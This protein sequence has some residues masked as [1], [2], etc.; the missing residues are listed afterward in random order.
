MPPES[1]GFAS[2]SQKQPTLK[3]DARQ[4]T[5][6]I[7]RWDLVFSSKNT[8]SEM[9]THTG[10]F[11]GGLGPPLRR[12]TTRSRAAAPTRYRTDPHM[13]TLDPTETQ[14]TVKNE[15]LS[16]SKTVK[17]RHEATRKR[18]FGRPRNQRLFTHTKVLDL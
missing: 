12:R 2:V 1:D 6:K 8:L 15:R 4:T 10:H 13:R 3:I 17:L 7:N 16:T 18:A 9:E 14:T 11:P 5:L